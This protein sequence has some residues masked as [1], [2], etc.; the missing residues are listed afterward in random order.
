MSKQ[1]ELTEI[2]WELD[3]PEVTLPSTVFVTAKTKTAAF[4][5]VSH[6]YGYPIKFAVI[7]LL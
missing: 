6:I 2:Q 3:D 7:E 5:Q 4:E 1:Y